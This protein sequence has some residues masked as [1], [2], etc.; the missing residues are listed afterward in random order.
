MRRTN[1]T[2]AGLLAATFLLAAGSPTTGAAA[3]QTSTPIQHLVVIFDENNSFD[4]YFGTYPNATNP[5]GEPAFQAAPGT[6]RVNGISDGLLT[7]NPNST[8]PFRLDRSQEAVNCDNNNGYAAE[9]AAFD[10]GLMDQFPENTS[11][12]PTEAAGDEVGCPA[13]IAMGYYDGNT[14]TGLWNYA[15]HYAMSDNF[16]DT[17]FGT[18]LMGHLNLVS[19][20]T[21]QTFEPG[22]VVKTGAT[23]DVIR[24]GSVIANLDSSL[25][26]CRTK[27][28]GG[29]PVASVEMTGH[30]V[31]DLLNAAGVTWGWFYGDFAAADGST[32]T[33]GLCSE[34]YDVHYAPF[35]YYQSTANPHHLPPTSTELIGQQADQANH[36]YDLAAFHAALDGGY[37]PA[38]TF[39]KA[40]GA[41]TGH[42]QTSDALAEQ[43]FLVDTINALQQSKYWPNMAIAIAYDDSDGWY[44]HVM[45]P[46]VNQSNDQGIDAVCGGTDLPDGAFNDRCGYGE[47]MPFLV[48]SPYA[49]RNYVDHAVMD[50][51]SILRFIEDNWQLGRIDSLDYPDGTPSGS[52]PRGQASFDRIAGDITGL[53][54]FETHPAAPQ[55]I[56]DDSTGE[57]VAD[58]GTPTQAPPQPTQATPAATPATVSQRAFAEP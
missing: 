38:V 15:Q 55:L 49:R 3:G 24:N 41:Q 37:L 22:D 47:R 8:A 12:G 50:L 19:G 30:N 28:V 10:H 52:P 4:H 51:T 25:D 13:G 36:Q 42:P 58:A 54:D 32:P 44:D 53:F 33:H 9:Q 46:I 11:A 48:I 21:H 16:Y 20:Q 17:E 2:R 40:P 43:K 35:Q 27:P 7:S 23:S 5:A 26:D 56:L 6:P 57:V 29:Q 1:I 39:L 31:G 14:V 18:T 45:P 34:D